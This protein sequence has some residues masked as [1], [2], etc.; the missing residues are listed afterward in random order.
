MI[1]TPVTNIK[2][3]VEYAYLIN[4]NDHLQIVC[5]NSNNKIDF[6]K[7]FDLIEEKL[8]QITNKIKFEKNK[9]FGYLSSCVSNCGEALK[10]STGLNLPLLSKNGNFVFLLSEWDIHHQFQSKSD[11]IGNNEIIAKH[12]NGIDKN[13]F[14]NSYIVKICSLIN[15]ENKL[16]EDI[17]YKFPSIAEN[18]LSKKLR[19]I[20]NSHSRSL[21]SI[22]TP[23]N[24]GFYSI[25]KMDKISKRF[26]LSFQD[27]ESYIIFKNVLSD[28]IAEKTNI[29]MNLKKGESE[30]SNIKKIITEEI[31]SKNLEDFAEMLKI[32]STEKLNKV[33][34]IQR[35]NLKNFNFSNSIT[36][37]YEE[38]KS[39]FVKISHELLNAVP[40]K[41]QVGDAL[42]ILYNTNFNLIFE[43]LKEYSNIPNRNVMAYLTMDDSILVLFNGED[44]IKIILGIES[45]E[46]FTEDFSYF[47]KIFDFLKSYCSFDEYFGYLTSN[48]CNSG[49]GFEIRMNFSAKDKKYL[50]EIKNEIR[51]FQL[52]RSFSLTSNFDVY[53]K[54][55]ASF[56]PNEIL[57]NAVEYLK[58]IAPHRENYQHNEKKINEENDTQNTEIKAEKVNEVEIEVDTQTN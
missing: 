43:E 19:S 6:R 31:T 34:F 18:Y 53:N 9:E 45:Y 54:V 32:H 22:V 37:K 46:R 25:F 36:E 30:N 13:V 47:K 2:N 39:T 16:A 27:K 29:S 44:Q 24:K 51:T 8:I 42:D 21:R 15:F 33:F 57:Q 48:P 52:S 41:L 4:F 38:L 17:N 40:G 11:N 3:P 35:M 14:I 50:D 23:N 12:R 7:C 28:Y 1:P 20:Y 10:I 58:S 49:S 55:K 26:N 5:Y 56:H